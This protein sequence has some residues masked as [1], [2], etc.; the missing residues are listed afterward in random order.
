MPSKPRLIILANRRKPRVIEALR[1]LLPWLEQRARIV[2]QPDLRSRGSAV[3]GHTA[4]RRSAALRLPKADLAIVLG[5]D[6]TLLAQVR[7]MADRGVPLVG[8]NFGKLGF[9]AS[10]SLEDFQRE[11]PKIAAGRCPISR[12]LLIDVRVFDTGPG[13]PWVTPASKTRCT[14]HAVALNDAVITAG[15]P[16]RMIELK[17]A[18]DPTPHSPGATTFSGDGVV[19][20][21]PS[22]ST[23][24]NLSANGPIV[25]P[26]VE[27][28]CITPIC[29]HGL[30]FRPIVVSSQSRVVVR[31]HL[32]NPG[33]TLVIDGQIPV[34]LKAGQQLVVQRHAR[35]LLLVDHP[36]ID[37]WQM[38]AHKMHWGA[39]P[40]SG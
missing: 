39:R 37:Y 26:V 14:F 15:Q 33:T 23:A 4:A 36:H 38:L 20:A 3:V 13:D 2:A 7:M 29:P 32:P 17:L 34:V 19:I 18:I 5:G 21:T 16:F 10:F 1:G 22:G 9:L 27:A 31:T 35:P 30:A 11:W 40:R 6:G 28:L 25:S 24:Y 12:R 8:V